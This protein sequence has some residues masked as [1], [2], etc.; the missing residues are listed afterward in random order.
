MKSPATF[1]ILFSIITCFLFCSTEKKPPEL[2]TQDALKQKQIKFLKN[3]NFLGENENIVYFYSLSKIKNE[4][5]LL[6]DKKVLVYNKEYT[7]KELFE[8]I[9]D[10]STSH[11]LSAEKNSTINVYRKDDTEFKA[12]FLGATD[13]DENFFVTLKQKWR[14]ALDKKSD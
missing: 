2:L 13:S 7:D 3:K 14:E 6:T 9:F 8:N 4:G 1:S 10:I 5:I 11:S 12:E